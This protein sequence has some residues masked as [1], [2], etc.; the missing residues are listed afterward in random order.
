MLYDFTA[1]HENEVSVKA[2]DIITVIETAD[3][4]W[5]TMV[6]NDSRKVFECVYMMWLAV[7]SRKNMNCVNLLEWT[8]TRL[9]CGKIWQ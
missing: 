3:D 6:T 8:C 7:S 2:G 4:G 9:L 1:Q 5:F